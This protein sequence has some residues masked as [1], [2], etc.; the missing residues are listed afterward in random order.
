MLV[1]NY[2]QSFFNTDS[3]FKPLPQEENTP[4]RPEF[5]VV[6]RGRKFRPVYTDPIDNIKIYYRRTKESNGEFEWI[7]WKQLE[8]ADNNLES[9]AFSLDYEFSFNGQFVFRAVPCMQEIP[10]GGYKEYEVLY[11]EDDS[12]QWSAIQISEDSF[13]AACSKLPAPNKAEI[14]CN[15]SLLSKLA[16]PP[17]I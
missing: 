17:P 2:N 5:D 10:I 11:E 15:P 6:I 3:N 1:H 4:Q 13:I 14:S 8:R 12:L 9:Q 7:F 16:K